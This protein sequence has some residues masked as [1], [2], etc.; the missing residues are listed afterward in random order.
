MRKE[1][2]DEGNE[3]REWLQDGVRDAK[4]GMAEERMRRVKG[5]GEGK[6]YEGREER[7]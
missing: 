4:Q 5:E 6:G 2:G 1:S 7:E 3:R